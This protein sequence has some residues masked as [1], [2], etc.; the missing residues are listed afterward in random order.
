MKIGDLVYYPRGADEVSFN[1]LVTEITD[2][3]PYG[4]YHW[5]YNKRDTD[6]GVLSGST[7]GFNDV[8]TRPDA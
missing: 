7:D 8:I 5:H 2:G 1:A 6:W 3:S 4:L